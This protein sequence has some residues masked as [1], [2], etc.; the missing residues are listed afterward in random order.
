MASS[1]SARI[2]PLDS[3][4]RSLAFFS[5]V[6]SGMTEPGRATATVWPAA[7]FGAPQTIVAA[8]RSPRSDADRRAA[9]RR[10]GAVPHDST[11]PTTK[12]SRAGD[13]VVVDRLDLGAGHR[14]AL[15][16]LRRRRGPGRS[17]RAASSAGPSC[18]RPRER[19]GRRCA[20]YVRATTTNRA[21]A[22]GQS[23]GRLPCA[24]ATTDNTHPNCSRKRRSLS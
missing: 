21:R 13:A 22:P 10:R 24:T 7:T 11:W 12:R 15:L 6:P 18:R 20:E 16:E 4:P 17:T 1:S 9:G 2:I 14:Q 5:L 8:R 19:V 23:P 3:T